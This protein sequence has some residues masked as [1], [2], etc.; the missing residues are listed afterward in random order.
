MANDER[1]LIIDD[2]S[3]LIELITEYLTG[4]GYSVS[5]LPNGDNTLETLKNSEP[6][7]IILDVMMPGKDGFEILNEIRREFPTPIIMLTAKGEETDRI[8]GLEMGADDYIAKP[9]NPRE[10]LARI[11]AVLRRSGD[12]NTGAQKKISSGGITLNTGKQLLEIDDDRIELS[13]T[14]FRL[15]KALMQNVNIALT[16]DELMTLVWDK[17]F[18][19]FDRSIDVHISKLRSLLKPYPAHEKRIRTVWGTGYMFVEGE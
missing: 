9:F 13:H 14:E 7:I 3:K 19:A 11:K 10:L 15:F 2:D 4:Y 6:D 18:T 16:R 1:V 5:S 8:V 17:D 12:K